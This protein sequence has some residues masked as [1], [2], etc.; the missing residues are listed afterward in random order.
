MK[1]NISFDHSESEMV[2]NRVNKKTVMY[3]AEIRY[4]QLSTC[5]RVKELHTLSFPFKMVALRRPYIFFDASLSN[6]E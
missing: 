1:R 4:F 5:A 2:N 3:L 6:L